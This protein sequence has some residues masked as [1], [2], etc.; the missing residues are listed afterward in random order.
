MH[1]ILKNR[2]HDYAEVISRSLRLREVGRDIFE[3]VNSSSP[4]DVAD[5]GVGPLAFIAGS[6]SFRLDI[7]VTASLPS[8]REIVSL[9]KTFSHVHHQHY[10]QRGRYVGSP[11]ETSDQQ[12]L[13]I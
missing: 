13:K 1:L 4:Y 9:N 5:M 12:I 7:I 2:R 3:V 10:P 11:I 6:K 8:T